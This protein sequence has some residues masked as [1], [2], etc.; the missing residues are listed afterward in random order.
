MCI[1]F[2]VELKIENLSCESLKKEAIGM[3]FYNQT[4]PFIEII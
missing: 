3:D 4:I 2:G 1:F